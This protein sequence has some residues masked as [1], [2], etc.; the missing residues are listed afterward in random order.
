M[1]DENAN[2]PEE[3]KGPP[4]EYKERMELIKGDLETTMRDMAG[5]LFEQIRIMPDGSIHI[6]LDVLGFK[7][8]KA[9]YMIQRGF[10][11]GGEGNAKPDDS[12]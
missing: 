6:R 2:K 1:T 5:V 4:P 3:D 12:V 9:H 8:K 11:Y 10:D 7:I